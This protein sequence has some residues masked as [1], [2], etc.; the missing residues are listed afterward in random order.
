MSQEIVK[1]TSKGQLTIPAS[2]RGDSGLE[3]GSYIYM[4]SLGGIVIMKKVDDLS[5]DEITSLLESLAR[6]KGLTKSI[7]TSEIER[8]RREAWKKTHGK[9][10]SP[11][12]H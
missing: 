9:A 6:E 5:I 8:V 3:E 1:V 10:K 2:I 4:K 12:G 11:S 7:L